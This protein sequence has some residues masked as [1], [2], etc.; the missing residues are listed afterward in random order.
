MLTLARHKSTV[1]PT[2]VVTHSFDL[3]DP[4]SLVLLLQAV[5]EQLGSGRSLVAVLGDWYARRAS[6]AR[7][8]RLISAGEH[9]PTTG[10]REHIRTS[11]T[12][13]GGPGKV[14]G[15]G[16]VNES[17]TVGTKRMRRWNGSVVRWGVREERRLD[18]LVR[19]Y[20]PK[21][22]SSWQEIADALGSGR[23][24]GAVL[25]HWQIMASNQL[26]TRGGQAAQTRW[27]TQEESKLQALVVERSPRS[28]A[29]E[30]QAI[31]TELGTGLSGGVVMQHWHKMT[32][33]PTGETVEELA[34]AEDSADARAGHVGVGGA[35]DNASVCAAFHHPVPMDTHAL[36]QVAC[37]ADGGMSAPEALL[38]R[39]VNLGHVDTALGGAAPS[40]LRESTDDTPMVSSCASRNGISADEMVDSHHGD[41]SVALG[42]SATTDIGEVPA[43]VEDDVCTLG[44]GWSK[45]FV[46]GIDATAGDAGVALLCEDDSSDG[47]VSVGIVGGLSSAISDVIVDHAEPFSPAVAPLLHPQATAS[48]DKMFWNEDMM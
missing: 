6:R 3:M 39:L 7:A 16:N 46:G 12:A 28:N 20:Q 2:A 5:A 48:D 1:A 8:E 30:W 14:M 9:A 13:A 23:T 38:D 43:V 17:G 35:L 42:H 31:A 29:A 24:G 22:I 11:G 41:R 32:L 47:L 4:L 33:S 40:G 34:R 18:D 37:A 10:T 36:S 45:Q 44:D 27:N 15:C 26:G 19:Q 21:T 25:Q